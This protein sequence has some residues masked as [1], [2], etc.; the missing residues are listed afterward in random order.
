MHDMVIRGGR[1]FDGT[2]ADP[3]VADVA[4]DNGKITLVGEVEASGREEINAS[5]RRLVQRAS[6]Y[7]AT[8]IAG[9]VAFRDGEPTG[10]L[11]GKL[12]RVSQ[13]VPLL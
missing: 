1:V 2:G 5:G 8:I 11:N 7:K 10:E 9:K 6:G 4:I 12:I 3:V 13:P